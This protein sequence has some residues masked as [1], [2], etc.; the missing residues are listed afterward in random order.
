M[1]RALQSRINRRTTRYSQ[2]LEN[3]DD[4]AGQATDDELVDALRNLAQREG[5]LHKITREIVLG[6]NE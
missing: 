4:P 2:L 1:L 6:K 5:K 3:V